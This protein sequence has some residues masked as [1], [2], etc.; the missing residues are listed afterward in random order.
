MRSTRNGVSLR[1]SSSAQ[2]AAHRGRRT[3]EGTAV[4]AASRIACNNLAGINENLQ[5][6]EGTRT[7]S[8][9]VAMEVTL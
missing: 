3:A 9:S 2:R 6:R 8:G 5:L 7:I 4:R 1:V